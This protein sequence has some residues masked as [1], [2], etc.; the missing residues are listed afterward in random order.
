MWNKFT[1]RNQRN[2]RVHKYRILSH[3]SSWNQP[4]KNFYSRIKGREHLGHSS[5]WAAA[6][7]ELSLI[8]LQLTGRLPAT[9]LNNHK[10]NADDLPTT[11]ILIQQKFYVHT[12]PLATDSQARDLW[13]EMAQIRLKPEPSSAAPYTYSRDP[14]TATPSSSLYRYHILIIP[15][16]D[17]SLRTPVPR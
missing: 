1:E 13:T 8:S 16:M 15:A 3:T 9:Q 12:P 7:V 5:R 10:N 2:N 11:P 14:T 17:Q 6:V 4:V